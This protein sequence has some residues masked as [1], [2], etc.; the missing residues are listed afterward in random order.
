MRITNSMM[1]KNAMYDLDGLRERYA[2][3]QDAVNGRVLQRPSEDPQRVAEAMDLTGTKDRL[4]IARRSGQDATQWLS[5]TEISMNAVIEHLQQVRELAVQAGNPATMDADAREALAQQITTLR[6]GIV[7]HMN[8]KFQGQYL[9]AGWKTDTEPFQISATGGA[10][11]SGN[12]GLITREVAPGLPI[13][14]NL[15]GDQLTA[16]GDFVKT[17]TDMAADLR[18]GKND[19]V[20][21]TGLGDLDTAIGNLTVLRSDLGTRQNQIEQYDSYAQENLLLIQ[22]RLSKT[23]GADLASAVL[24]MTQAQTSYQAALSSFAK[25]LPTSLLDYLK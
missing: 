10:T 23:T 19:S 25:A 6:D 12:S 14:T 11:Y 21:S 1:L 3:A 16:K 7:H 4:E 15:T 13:T 18:A 22:D 2:K 17:L 9:F 5:A 20:I 24:E 8:D